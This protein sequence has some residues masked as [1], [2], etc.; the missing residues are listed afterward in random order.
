MSSQR[1]GLTLPRDCG[2]GGKGME[3]KSQK[4]QGEGAFCF[5]G[6]PLG[7]VPNFLDFVSDLKG[8]VLG[9][10]LRVCIFVG[11]KYFLIRCCLFTESKDAFISSY[12]AILIYSLSCLITK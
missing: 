3:G 10:P 4:S 6:L 8:K 2:T 1:T 12:F 5:K 9:R 7:S 11:F